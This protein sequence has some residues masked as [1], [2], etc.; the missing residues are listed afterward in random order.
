MEMNNATRVANVYPMS[1]NSDTFNSMKNDFDQMLRTLLTEME[2]RESEE[3]T[4]NVKVQ[5]KL[6]PDQARDFQANGYD[7]QRDFIKPSFKHEISTVLQVK[8]KKT[9]SF[10]GNMELV[11]DAPMNQY[12]MRPIDNGQVSFFDGYDKHED[13][14]EYVDVD[15]VPA[16]PAP[17]PLQLV[18]PKV[19]NIIES[20]L[21]IEQLKEMDHESLLNLAKELG[22]DVADCETDDEIAAMIAS[23][24]VEVPE[25]AVVA[26]APTAQCSHFDW[27]SRFEGKSLDVLKKGDEYEAITENGTVV[28]S[29]AADEGSCQYIPKEMFDDNSI[30]DT[31]EIDKGKATVDGKEIW[32]IEVWSVNQ[33]RTLGSFYADVQEQVLEET[34]EVPDDYQYED[35]QTEN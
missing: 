27:L 33:E 7:A 29:T 4:I 8:N 19:I 25:E 31:L 18:E 2:T 20:H 3:G 21:D 16:L 35:P 5:V 26:E 11:W 9:G 10:G 24:K 12:I 1:L 6:T 15:T 23:E 28:L 14:G 34:V 22:L 30:D 13:D 17:E 32:T